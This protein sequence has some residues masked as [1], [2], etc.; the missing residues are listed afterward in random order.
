METV[1]FRDV[2]WSVARKAGYSPESGNFITNQA[3][4]IGEYINDWVDRLYAQEDWPQWTKVVEVAPVDHIVPYEFI[5]GRADAPAPSTSSFRLHRVV[6]V[7]LIDPKTTRSPVT[8]HFTL[9]ED[10]VHCGYEHGTNVWIKYIEPSPTFTAVP[11][12]GDFTYRKNDAVY[13]G[14]TG[15]CYRSAINSNRGHDPAANQPPIPPELTID[16]TQPFTPT[17]PGIPPQTQIV[18]CQV[19]Y[20]AIDSTV[21]IPDPIPNG[22]SFTLGLFDTSGGSLAAHSQIQGGTTSTADLLAALKVM[23]DADSLPGFT[24]TVLAGNKFRIES[25]T[26]EFVINVW[27]Y[28][29]PTTEPWAELKFI[30][31]Q[32]FSAGISGADGTPQKVKITIGDNAFIPGATYSLTIIDLDGIGHVVEYVSNSFDNRNQILNGLMAAVGASDV[33]VVASIGTSIDTAEQS[34]TLTLMRVLGVSGEAQPP[35]SQFWQLVPFPESLFNPVVRG[36]T[37]A[38][39][40]EW[41]ETDK[42]GV[43]EQKVPMET[44]INRGDFETTPNPQLTTQ[45]RVASRYKV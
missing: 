11:W 30:Q 38:L 44:N 6:T 42:Q 32:P 9:R 28:F 18:D 20:A 1:P 36:A 4:P 27:R 10:G 33:P 12:R 2:L 40:G 31:I 21:P 7:Y 25:T 23:F 8:T 29:T 19:A 39:L 14:T 5:L 13:S 45:Q 17:E 16:E 26:T 37:A 34:A 41:G 35:A 22:Y 24:F 3:I 43:E 15:E